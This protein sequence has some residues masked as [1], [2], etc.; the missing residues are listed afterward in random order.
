MSEETSKHAVYGGSSY[1]RWKNCPG[2]INLIRSV[3]ERPAGAAAREGSK[4]HALAEYCLRHDIQDARDVIKM[5]PQPRWEYA[6]WYDTDM[7]EAVNVYLGV[8]YS[9]RK[10]YPS[11]REWIEVK[12]HPSEKYHAECYGSMDYGMYHEETG[13]LKIVD[14]KNGRI[15]VDPE[16]NDQE[17]FYAAAAVRDCVKHDKPLTSV[18]LIIVQPNIPNADVMDT[19]KRWVTSPERLLRVP[20]EIDQAILRTKSPSAPFVSGD[21][22]AFCPAG[23]VCEAFRASVLEE[24]HLTYADLLEPDFNMFVKAPTEEL[25]VEELA[26]LIVSVKSVKAWCDAVSDLAFHNAL[27]GKKIPGYKLVEKSG[28]R[29]WMGDPAFIG[30]SLQ[31]L[32]G[33]EEDDVMPR[34]LATITQVETKLK[35]ELMSADAFKE[36]KNYISIEFMMKE[37]SG[38]KLVSESEKGEAVSPLDATAIYADLLNS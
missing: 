32:Y 13:T 8:I 11:A 9:L 23:A 5:N 22:C 6:P 26:R 2:S 31:L 25:S 20:A 28:K 18:E 19:V 4:A 36:A 27:A 16:E 10:A 17:L 33:L 1:K 38:L 24:V 35:A 21:W 34:K 30:Q 14:Y 12:V 3:P 29:K 7:V 37:S 15:E